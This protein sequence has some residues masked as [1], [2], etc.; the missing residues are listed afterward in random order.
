MRTGK[1][2]VFVVIVALAM[3]MWAVIAA[4]AP[5]GSETDTRAAIAEKPPLST[6][7][8]ARPLGKV[9]PA[10]H[11]EAV[12]WDQPISTNGYGGVSGYNTS[13]LFGAYSADDFQNALPWAIGTIFV[14]GFDQAANLLRATSLT[15]YIYPDAAG[16]PAG[17]PGDGS[18]AEIWSLSLPPTDPA[19]TI[20][21]GGH[22][23]VTLNVALATGGPLNL[24]PGYYWLVFYPSLDWAPGLYYWYFAGTA[25]LSH[26]QIIDPTDYFGAGF[27]SWTDWTL[28]DPTYTDMA[29]RLEGEVA[30][31]IV[32]DKYIDSEPWTPGM[33]ITRQ[34]SDTIT[35][36]EV[37]HLS[38]PPQARAAETV[39]GAQ[40]PQ[41]VLPA[42]RVGQSYADGVAGAGPS[43]APP[44]AALTAIPPPPG[45]IVINFDDVAAP[46]SFDQTTALRDQY[47]GLGVLF[48]GP[49]ANDGGGVLDQCGNFG[50]SGHS[51][52][53]FLAFNAGSAFSNGGIP[54]PPETIT[55]INGASYVQVNAGSYGGA[56][57]IVTMEAF[58][59]AGSSLGSDSLTLAST[60]DT[61]SIT[62]DEIAWVVINTPAGVLVLDDLAFLPPTVPTFI[63]IE[64][65]DPAHLRLL[66]WAATGGGV[67]VTPGRV[68]W[69]GEI[70]AP[71]TITLTKWFHVEPCTWTET[72]LWEELWLDGVE[73]EQR[74][75]VV[76]KLP[77]AL[78]IDALYETSVYAGA[79]ANFTL[80][81]GNTGGFDNEV[82]IRNDFPPVAPFA[83]SVP[84]PTNVDPGGLWAEWNLGGLP[85]GAA[86]NIDVTVMVQ[87]G[88]PPSTTIE[89]WDGIL[90]HTGELR[91]WV[92]IIFHVPH[93]T[94]LPLVFKGYGHP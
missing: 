59:A 71:T 41:Q 81:Y 92:L 58:D 36:Q 89:I 51:P 33:T 17:Y 44:Q 57:Q 29:F 75:V 63:Q 55:F 74:P 42:S 15:W 68:E 9:K 25:N 8:P 7:S 60:L 70:V 11:P 38:P 65:W 21:L 39:S 72:V 40:P 86:G 47:A 56:G 24:P 10:A 91:D 85:Q 18:G 5:A 49:A 27:T 37:L 73:L 32:W 23:D 78:W 80:T 69:T 54:R 14:D 79:P 3:G 48:M 43:P 88:L 62:A 35:V 19:V 64:T 82:W 13:G 28:I 12:L 22:Q 30:S 93:R 83:G 87:P 50:V 1:L 26:P 66:D 2:L 20:G 45:A 4:A 53:N 31:P 61:L 84:P 94:H 90:D 52:P 46:C 76:N 34:T 6:T 16:V 67:I 77:P